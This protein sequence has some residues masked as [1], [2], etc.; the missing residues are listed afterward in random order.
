[1]KS[2]S[3]PQKLSLRQLLLACVLLFGFGLALCLILSPGRDERRFREFG[4]ALFREEL[5][6]NTLSLHYTLVNPKRFGI[7]EYPV[8]LPC[9]VAGSASSAASSLEKTLKELRCIRSDHLGPEARYAHTCLENSLLSAL[10]LSR[11]PY[12][13]EPFSPAHGIQSQLPILLSEYDFRTKKDVEEYLTLL[14]QTGEFLDSFLLYE[15]EKAC[16]GLLMSMRSL[17]TAEEQC[18]TIV[19]LEALTDK[20]HFL[21]TGFQERLTEL[22][23]L[24]PLQE[25]ELRAW[26]EQND[27]LLISV[28]YPAYQRLKEGLLELE[29]LAPS[30]TAGL[31]SLPLGKEYYRALLRHETGSEKSPEDIRLLLEQTLITESETIKQLARDY[32]ACIPALDSGNYMDLGIYDTS[33]MIESLKE[34]MAEEFP[35]LTPL[36]D[37]ILKEVTPDLQSSSAPAFYLTAPADGTDRNVIYINPQ[38]AAHGLELYVTLAHEGYPGHLYQNAYTSK[39]ILSDENNLLRLLLSTGG[40]LEGWALYVE[41]RSYDYASKLLCDQ[42]RPA[43]AVC[44]QLEKHNRSLQ[45]CLYSLLDL[46]IHYDGATREEVAAYLAPLGIQNAGTAGRIYDYICQAPCNYPKYYLG[47]LEILALKQDA[48]K[49]WGNAYSELSFHEFLLKWGPADFSSL[50]KMLAEHAESEISL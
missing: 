35:A 39:Q 7:D 29:A 49:L 4:N 45:L 36:P 18:D 42:G 33:V 38:N 44:V 11:F 23:H 31:S 48:V 26:R 15:S 37:V 50:R 21:Q 5:T 14:S 28:L 46:L 25:S 22:G 41:Q 12:Y 43:D 20:S 8:R 34:K 40:Y 9:Y 16:R 30:E 10:E 32:P 17:R 24:L 3:N 19:T 47:Y 2:E 6:S 27:R 13:D 1:M